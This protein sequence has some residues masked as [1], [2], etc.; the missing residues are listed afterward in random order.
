MSARAT[1]LI[2]LEDDLLL[3]DDLEESENVHYFYDDDNNFFKLRQRDMPTREHNRLAAYLVQ[4]LEWYYRAINANHE[5]Y[6]EFNFYTTANQE[7]E[8]LYPDI[9]VVKNYTHV[10]GLNSHQVN[11]T[12]PAPSVVIE[13]ISTKTRQRDISP[14]KK[15]QFYAD[16]GTKEYFA[17][18]PRPRKRKLKMRRLWGWQLHDGVPYPLEADK[19]GRLWS[20]ELDSWLVPAG[21]KLRLYDKDN[22]L[23]LTEQEAEK[24]ARLAEQQARI[25]AERREKIEQEKNARLRQKLRELGIDPDKI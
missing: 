4:V 10:E 20:H 24:A 25:E 19:Q 2:E 8:P 18:D 16:W 6:S 13:L 7:E 1:N 23:R 9:A 11:V 21:T 22:N 12:C 17:Y 3:D 15:P 5:V 14:D